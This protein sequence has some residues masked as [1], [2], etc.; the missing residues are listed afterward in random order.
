MLS[1]RLLKKWR[2]EA[3]KSFNAALYAGTTSG[4]SKRAKGYE[5]AILRMTQELLD[6]H[7]IQQV[8]EGRKEAKDE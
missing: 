7:L 5:Q 1:E 8:G 6:Q 2:G 3:L 4:L